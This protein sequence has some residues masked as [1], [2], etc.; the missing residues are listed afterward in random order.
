MSDFTHLHLH[1]Q[2]SILDGLSNIS[3]LIDRVK[4]LGMKSVAITDHGNMFGVK[5]FHK[6]AKKAGIKPIIGCE[7]Y[8]ARRSRHE[9]VLKEDRSGNHLVILAKNKIGYHNLMKLVSYGWT[10]GFYYRPRIDKELLFKYKEGL[11]ISTACLG[12]EIPRTI[13]NGKIQ[14]VET[15]VKEFKEQFGDDFYLE[16]QRHQ[17]G[18]K[19]YDA[20]L[21]DKQ[22][23]VNKH[24]IEIAQKYDVKYIATN[25]VHFV[26]QEDAPAHDLLICLSTHKDL[27]DPTRMKYSGQEFVKS[28]QQMKKIF[29]DLPQALANTIE[30]ENK[31]EQYELNREPIMPDFPL[32]EGFTSEAEY[33]RHITYEGAK[34]RWLNPSQEQMERIDFELETILR[35]GFP[36]YFLIVWDFIKA[37]RQMG[38]SVGPGRGSAAGSA[39]AYCLQITDIDPIKYD[40]LFERFLNPERIS[41]P[42]MDIDFDDDGRALVIDWVVQKYGKNRVANIVTFGSMAAKSSLKDVGRILGMQPAETDKLSKMVPVKPGTTLKSALQEVP[43]LA[44]EKKNGSKVVTQTF[45]YAETLEGTIRQTGVHACGIIIGKDDLEN[46]VPLSISKESDLYVTQYNGKNIEDVG[47]LKM[48]FLGLKT[49]SIIKDAIEY[50]KHSKGIS[51]DIDKISLEDKKTYELFARAETTGIFQFESDGMKKYLKQLKP[52]R[53]EDLIAM[54]ALYRPGPMDYIPQFIARKNGE[55][56]I[57]YDLPEMEEFLANTYGITVYQEQ[58]MQLSQK[59]AGFTKGQADSL[60]KAM[61]KKM[62]AMMDELKIKFID[63]AK[64]FGHSEKITEKIWKDW[65]AFA[66][67]AFNKSHSTCYAYIAYQTAYLKAHYP[68][69]FMAAVL[70]RNLTD[71]EKIGFFMDECKKIGVK[72][73]VP[74]VNESIA[75][76]SVN[77]KGIVRFGLNAIKGVGTNVVNDIVSERERAGN[78]KDYFDFIERVNL[79]SVTKKTMESLAISGAFD[80]FGE[81]KRS[82]FFAHNGNS[83]LTFIEECIRYGSKLQGEGAGSSLFG[84][85]NEVQIVKPEIPQ[86]PEWDKLHQLKQ[87][88]ELVGIFLS[89]HPL[90]EYR[91]EINNYC[92]PISELKDLTK[93][94]GREIKIAG[95]I[96]TIQHST[97]KTGNPYGSFVIE[98]FS[99]SLKISLFGKSYPNFKNFLVENYVILIKGKVAGKYGREDELEFQPDQMQMLSEVKDK[100]IKEITVKIPLDV[101]SDSFINDFNSTVDLHKGN[102]SLK[103][104]LFDPDTNIWIQMLS[105]KKKVNLTN[106]LIEFLQ[107]TPKIDYRIA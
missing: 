93:Y 77:K 41:M 65:E 86:A 23:L 28:P 104:L 96:N 101:I 4:E 91:L 9:K 7:V 56:K 94:K 47:M 90:D 12:G 25:D 33:L 30:I 57:T 44:A 89:E 69:E 76:F 24:I 59:L 100:M 31:I 17:T 49:L 85:G 39:V 97:T 107:N 78:Y 50:I 52:T 37:A 26:L 51:V 18:N 29:E 15:L 62:I 46:Y 21:Y 74:D 5:D 48:D 83:P 43:E 53:F 106:G 13:S 99:S 82:Q 3:K 60:R 36:G 11:I 63:G 54:N 73:L 102:S 84:G 88:K 105:R 103:V 81:I 95:I 71:I 14:E 1:T 75:K 55:Q 58:V 16:M 70:S 32:P 34:Y 72:V 45:A 6:T 68:A 10:E 80:E 61:G 22:Q 35:M 79:T 42:D 92:T 98:D 27:N 40:L 66:Q 8:V 2:Y 19:E 20:T 64:K 87:E 67:Y 38:V